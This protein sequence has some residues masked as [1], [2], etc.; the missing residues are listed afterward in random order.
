MLV[1]SVTAGKDEG[2]TERGT[3]H[4]NECSYSF[5]W[6]SFKGIKRIILSTLLP[7]SLKEKYSFIDNR[8][9]CGHR[10]YECVK[11]SYLPDFRDPTHLPDGMR[12][13]NE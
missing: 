3:K 7:E 10:G 2:E 5:S 9:T 11:A 13:T 12:A 6:L 4:G 8:K 1:F